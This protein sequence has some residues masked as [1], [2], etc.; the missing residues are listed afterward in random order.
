MSEICKYGLVCVCLWKGKQLQHPIHRYRY[1]VTPS[2]CHIFK[3][4]GHQDATAALYHLILRE[5]IALQRLSEL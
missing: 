4:G 5:V 1:S 2:S 3:T